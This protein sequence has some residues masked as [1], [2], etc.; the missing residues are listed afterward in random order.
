MQLVYSNDPIL[1]QP[2]KPVGQDLLD[3]QAAGLKPIAAT[4]IDKIHS[5][6]ALGISACQLGIDL[7]VFAISVD[8]KTRICANP[9]IVAAA[10][11][12]EK[13]NE[14]CLSFPGLYLKVNR[15][16]AV[17]VRYLNEDGK[18]VTEQLDGLTARAWLH[19][20]DHTIGICF[21]SRVTKL[22]LDIAKRRLNK[23]RRR[24][25]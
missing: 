10:T 16:A 25:K 8:G 24:T 6:N 19:E 21:T 11:D 3:N 13:A 23:Q 2:C 1:S 9:Q 4:L 17:V 20:Y 12:M 7:A 14:G 15:P 18:E 22:T 5:L